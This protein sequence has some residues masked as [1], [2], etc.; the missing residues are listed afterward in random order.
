M[1]SPARKN[2]IIRKNKFRYTTPKLLTPKPH[3]IQNPSD[4]RLPTFENNCGKFNCNQSGQSNIGFSPP[5]KFG[6]TPRMF[7]TIKSPLAGKTG[8]PLLLNQPSSTSTAN[9]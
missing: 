7:N 6:K 1:D 9:A 3:D 2:V 5:N 4:I 8:H